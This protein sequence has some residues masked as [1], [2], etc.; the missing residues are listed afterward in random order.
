MPLSERQNAM[1]NGAATGPIMAWQGVRR[2]QPKPSWGLVEFGESAHKPA[3]NDRA[4][5]ALVKLVLAVALV[6]I[7][8]RLVTA[9]AA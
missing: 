6:L 4:I 5:R 1:G 8:P 3:L 2:P 7:V 9:A